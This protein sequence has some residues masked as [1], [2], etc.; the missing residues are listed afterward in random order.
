MVIKRMA[1]NQT[2]SAL[3][4]NKN[5]RVLI[6]AC[7]TFNFLSTALAQFP[8]EINRITWSPEGTRV[9]FGKLD[10]TIEIINEI[11]QTLHTLT[12][13]EDAIL[14]IAW[15]PTVAKLASS[16]RDKTVKVWDANNGNLLLTL[17]PHQSPVFAVVWS[18]DSNQ[19]ISGSIEGSPNMW[20]WDAIQ[21]NLLDSRDR[22]S[23]FDLDYSPDGTL[24]AAAN[25]VGGVNFYD[26]TT[27]EANGFIYQPEIDQPTGIGQGYDT[28]S[29]VWSADGD[30]IIT[31]S[32]NGAVRLWNINVMHDKLLLDVM[33][34]ENQETN[35]GTTLVRSIGF[36]ADGNSILS[37]AADG[38][39]RIW[40]STTSELVNE[41][42]L[43]I[44]VSAAAFSHDGN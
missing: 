24:L 13:H 33:S 35:F 43:A 7:F 4:F 8:N 31:G 38:L 30:Q 11:G 1:V 19:I 44:S 25:P 18:P 5:Y 23:I 3:W 28:Y 37:V 32:L 16:S 36:G 42:Q 10:G 20:I 41:S 29:F 12:G 26:P 15:S 14:D 6:L 34:T 40:D 22:G 27:F 17:S 39:L 9:A 2:K 21:G